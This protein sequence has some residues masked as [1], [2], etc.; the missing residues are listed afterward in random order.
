MPI[1]RGIIDHQLQTLGEG[2]RWW[3]L[4]ELRDLPSVLQADEKILAI[5]RGKVA[6]LRWLRR[7]WL[8]VVTDRRL[9]CIRSAHRAGW[10]QIEVNAGHIE[11]VALRIGPFRGRLII[12]AGGYR[13]RLLVSRKDSHKLLSAFARVTTP[14]QPLQRITPTI[15]VRRVIDHMLALPAAAFSP[16]IEPLP[17][18]PDPAALLEADERVQSLE[19]EV[20]EL[21]K[22]VEF[23]E[24]LLRRTRAPAPTTPLPAPDKP[25][26]TMEPVAGSPEE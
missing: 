7:T 15:M 18:P 22:Q 13:Y 20:E 10:R 5:S 23:L 21:H 12:V 26:R 1:D 4:R 19:H 17:A 25:K 24:Q 14:L 11:R 6:R 16:S 8:I 2:T 3:E 9:L